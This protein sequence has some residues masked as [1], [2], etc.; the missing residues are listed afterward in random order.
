MIGRG[1][2]AD[3]QGYGVAA[4]LVGGGVGALEVAITSR[5]GPIVDTVAQRLGVG[6]TGLAAT[7]PVHYV[8]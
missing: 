5:Q 4:G 8:L 7:H 2:G 6:H 1:G 3:L